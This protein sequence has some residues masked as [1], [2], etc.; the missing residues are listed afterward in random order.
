MQDDFNYECDLHKEFVEGLFKF[1][2][3]L[4][5]KKPTKSALSRYLGKD[6]SYIKADGSI[7]WHLDIVQRCRIAEG[8][9]MKQ[10]EIKDAKKK[11]RNKS[12]ITKLT[13]ENLELKQELEKVIEEKNE[14]LKREIDLFRA[15]QKAHKELQNYKNNSMVAMSIN[16]DWRL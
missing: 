5:D 15:L 7:G 9:F 8:E 1:V 12:T 11:K 10:K 3:E 2:D 13:E 6:A 16:N 4:P 14:S